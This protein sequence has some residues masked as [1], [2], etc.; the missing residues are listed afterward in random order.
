V[1]VDHGPTLTLGAFWPSQGKG[2]WAASVNEPAGRI[3][4]ARV[5]DAGG[6]VL[7]TVDLT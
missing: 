3:R 1:V 4:A 2:A 6:H 5:V 7:A